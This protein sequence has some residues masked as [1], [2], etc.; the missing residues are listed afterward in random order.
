MAIRATPRQLEDR[1]P[2]LIACTLAAA[3]ILRT[4]DPVLVKSVT[5]GSGVTV[6]SIGRV[7]LLGLDPSTDTRARDRLA[8]LVLHRW[9]RLEF[10]D[11][12]RHRA[13][14]RTETGEFVNEIL[15]REGLARVA[16]RGTFTRRAEL[17][18]AQREAQRFRRGIWAR[19]TRP[20]S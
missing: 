5:D 20:S 11:G 13:Y 16:A 12:D 9:V 4:S 7:R 18:R 15:V 3:A 6:E 10:E 17:E 19:Y 2:I 1:M 8:S 14:V